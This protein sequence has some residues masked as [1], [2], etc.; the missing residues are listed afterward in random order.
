MTKPISASR[1]LMPTRRERGNG[2]CGK[3]R[4]IHA[5]EGAGQRHKAPGWARTPCARNAV[6]SAVGLEQ[7]ERGEGHVSERGRKHVGGRGA[8]MH[9]ASAPE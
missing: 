7:K 5:A 8:A 2:Q 4:G 9:R 6:R 3:V 1:A